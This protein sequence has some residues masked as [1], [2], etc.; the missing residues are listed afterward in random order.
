[1]ALDGQFLSVSEEFIKFDL[2]RSGCVCANLRLI[3]FVFDR[4]VLD[5]STTRS[6]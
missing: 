6:G 3:T 1:M 2:G 5:R 4:F